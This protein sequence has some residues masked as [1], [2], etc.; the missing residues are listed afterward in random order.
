MELARG[1]TS[2]RSL[3]RWK[4]APGSYCAGVEN[5]GGRNSLYLLNS[6]VD[7]N[8]P[9]DRDL[10]SRLYG[11]DQRVRVRQELLLGVGGVRALEALGVSPGVLHLNEGHSAFACLEMIRQR[12]QR[13]GIS[14][15]E[16]GA[17][18]P[19]RLS[20]PRIHPCRPDMIASRKH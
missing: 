2:G 20:L 17:A 5:V 18:W 13:E 15:E 9:E 8:A 3:W 6:D 14:F 16:R 4:R 11:G 7:G 19:D 12:M 1:K 10:T